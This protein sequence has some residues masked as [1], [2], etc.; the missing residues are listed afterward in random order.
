MTD[1][2]KLSGRNGSA[3]GQPKFQFSL[4][5]MAGTADIMN[6][7]PAD[8]SDEEAGIYTL[9]WLDKLYP[10]ITWGDILNATG[11]LKLSGWLGDKLK[12][13]GSFIGT[14]VSDWGD[15]VGEWGGDAI[16]LITDKEVREGVSQYAAAYGTGG[17]SEGITGFLKSLGNSVSPDQA[18]QLLSLIGAQTKIQAAAGPQLIQGV[19]NKVLLIGGA[20]LLVLLIVAR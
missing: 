11:N 10:G 12:D 19:D 1:L 4:F 17:A 7:D 2:V 14:G 9:Y 5:S 3:L 15:K 8:L 13:V 18:S 6:I 16:R 20:L